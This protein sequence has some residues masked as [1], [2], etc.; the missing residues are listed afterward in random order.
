MRTNSTIRPF[1][2]LALAGVFLTGC[3]SAPQVPPLPASGGVQ[4]MPTDMPS[5][6]H[7]ASGVR[8]FWIAGFLKEAA[9]QK[10][11][12]KQIVANDVGALLAALFLTSESENR[13]DWRLARLKNEYLQSDDGLLSALFQGR[14]KKKFAEYI[15]QEFGEKKLEDLPTRLCVAVLEGDRAEWGFRCSGRISDILEQALSGVSF[16]N[17]R[18]YSRL[19][20]STRFVFV[21][22]LAPLDSMV[23]NA[24]LPESLSVYFLEPPMPLSGG[25]DGVA[26]EELQKRTEMIYRGMLGF[27]ENAQ[28]I[29]EKVGFA[30][31]ASD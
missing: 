16:P 17:D 30:S 24:K 23:S 15:R 18:D 8:N 4:S 29:K 27:K 10:I 13:F 11:R 21:N 9:K 28:K 1:A 3:S 31:N 6:A 19:A 12:F 7:F 22:L 5:I 26:V 20:P 2:L 14:K 25:G